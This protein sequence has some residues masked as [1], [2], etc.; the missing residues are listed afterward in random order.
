M[1]GRRNFA[2]E[3]AL[4]AA[5]SPEHLARIHRQLT[6]HLPTY[7]RA[8]IGQQNILAYLHLLGMRRRNGRRLTW[9]IVERWRVNNGC[10]I[11]RGYSD[12][13]VSRSPLTTSHAMVA[14]LLSRFTSAD[15]FSM[16]NSAGHS[17]PMG[18]FHTTQ[19]A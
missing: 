17:P 7:D 9:R 19:A 16:V 3:R 11:L 18:C 13:R 14:W 10:P 6:Q 4:H 15:L 2:R 1:P 8:I 5:T 12:H